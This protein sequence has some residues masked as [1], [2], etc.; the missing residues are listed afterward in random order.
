LVE[1]HVTLT[2]EAMSLLND[3][4]ETNEPG[5][6]YN[7][8]IIQELYDLSFIGYIRTSWV[9][10]TALGRKYIQENGETNGRPQSDRPDRYVDLCRRDLDRPD[11][12]R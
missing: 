12:D 5:E 3:L 2:P 1:E 8:V 6:D 7:P 11:D 10:I 9:T 4:M